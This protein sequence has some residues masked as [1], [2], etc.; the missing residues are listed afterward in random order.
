MNS[1]SKILFSLA[2]IVAIYGIS[3]LF[4]IGVKPTFSNQSTASFSQN[5]YS[6]GKYN[7]GAYG[8]GTTSFTTVN[9]GYKVDGRKYYGSSISLGGSRPLSKVYYFSFMPSY[10]VIERGVQFVL[11]VLL[12]LLGAGFHEMR[13]WSIKVSDQ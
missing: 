4:M 13:N 2:A 11:A 6:S 12:V 7:N 10:S 5:G 1:L 8:G 9:Y 3:T